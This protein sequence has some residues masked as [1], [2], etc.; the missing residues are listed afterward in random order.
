MQIVL[1]IKPAIRTLFVEIWTSGQMFLL[2]MKSE[3]FVCS[4][5]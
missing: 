5:Q 3:Q 2:K 4:V 1:A